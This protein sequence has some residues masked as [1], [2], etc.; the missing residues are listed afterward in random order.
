[1]IRTEAT[2]EHL[3][4][5]FFKMATDRMEQEIKQKEAN[6]NRFRAFLF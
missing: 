5:F 1:M 2:D 6:T 3:I 4:H